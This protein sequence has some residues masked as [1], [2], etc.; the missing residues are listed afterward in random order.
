[1]IDFTFEYMCLVTTDKWHGRAREGKIHNIV[2]E[3]HRVLISFVSA[4]YRSMSS[5]LR[6]RSAYS[7]AAKL[8]HGSSLQSIY[9]VP[10][11]D[12]PSYTVETAFHLILKVDGHYHRLRTAEGRYHPIRTAKNQSDDCHTAA[13]RKVDMFLFHP[14]SD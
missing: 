4:F 11:T 8:C 12:L 9:T 3:L 7:R 13:Y 1:M 5:S 14:I 6:R 2:P 10:E